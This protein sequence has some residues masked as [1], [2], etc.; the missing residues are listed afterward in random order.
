MAIF[1]LVHGAWH[2]GWCWERVVPLLQAAGHTALAPDLPGMGADTTPFAEDVLGQWADAVIAL[3]EAQ[4]EPVV[5]VGHS[6]GGVVISEIAERAPGHVARLIYLTAFLLKDGQSLMGYVGENPQDGVPEFL[7][8]A[9][10]GKTCTVDPAQAPRLFYNRCAAADVA[11]NMARLKPEPTA[12]VLAPIRVSQER[13][14]AVPRDYIEM[15][16]DNAIAIG[17]QRD[18]QAHWPCERVVTVECD[19]SPFYVMP[20][21]LAEILGS[22]AT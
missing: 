9:E 10:D 1:V 15:T 2:G 5:L 8:I 21:R 3:I 20:E 4:A 11:A 7:R 19:H 22:L 12:A 14:G 13:F 6:R 18:M 16:D 17:L